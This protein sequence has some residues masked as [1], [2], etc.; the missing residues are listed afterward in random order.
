[1][2][3][4]LTTDIFIERA[5]KIHGIKYNY[6]NVEYIGNKI[7]I[8]IICIKHGVFTQSPSDHLSG[9]GCNKCGIDNRAKKHTK[10]TEKFVED[11][12]K[13]HNTLYDYSLVEYKN[14]NVNIKIICKKHGVFEQTPNNHLIGEGCGICGGCFELTTEEFIDKAKKIHGNRYEY[15]KSK[16]VKSIKKVIIICDKHGKFKQTPNKHLQGQ[17]CFK[18]S[19]NR[20]ITNEI[21]ISESNKKHNLK[22]DYSKVN[23]I[24]NNEKILIICREHG[25][26]KQQANSHLQGRGCPICKNSNGENI[27]S[28][29]LI[30]NKINF[31]NQYKFIECKNK[32]E[33][34]FDFYLPDYNLCIEYDGQLHF[35]PFKNNNKGI[36]KLKSTQKNDQ[37]KTEYCK[38]NNINLLRIPYWEFNNIECIL[39]TELKIA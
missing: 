18:C 39:K 28:N 27:V 23:Y 17:G 7:K 16:Y 32:R 4:Q 22:Y 1:M 14:W 24:G 10:S 26:F 21:F 20:P 12:K 3:Q 9:R 38:N 13:I 29:F 5:K 11:A 36:E 37:I 8:N 34:P 31:I 15:S 2:G 30:N 19:K 35:E 33:L 25:E 6:S